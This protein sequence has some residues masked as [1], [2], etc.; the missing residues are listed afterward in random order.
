LLL[1]QDLLAPA[2]G[3][4][5]GNSL[6]VIYCWPFRKKWTGFTELTRL[7]KES[8]RLLFLYPVHP[9]NPVFVVGSLAKA[10]ERGLAPALY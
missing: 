9:V 6:V 1:T 4:I 7:G 5:T 3:W 10:Q 8:L 2:P